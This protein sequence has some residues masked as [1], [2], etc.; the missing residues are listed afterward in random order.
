MD[1]LKTIASRRSIRGFL[2]KDV[3]KDII[4]K[5]IEA[6]RL[7]P[8]SKNCQPWNFIVF[9]GKAKTEISNVIRK[10]FKHPAWYSAQQSSVIKSCDIIDQAPVLILV[11]NTGPRSNGEKKVAKNSELIDAL[12]AEIGSIG[13]CIENMLLTATSLGLGSLWVGDVR[14]TD[15]AVEKYLK[16]DY[17]LIAGIALGYHNYKL[18]VKKLPKYILKINK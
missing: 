5:I 17:D 6:G 2:K 11:F 13:A 9:K 15:R 7:A 18:P 16:T 14:N 4:Q 1:V 12:I 8:S 10:N 3:K